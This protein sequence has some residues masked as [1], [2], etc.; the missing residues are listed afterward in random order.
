MNIK[1]LEFYR[2]NSNFT[3]NSIKGGTQQL[4]Y[5]DTQSI[6][7]GR[8]RFVDSIRTNGGLKFYGTPG[9]YSANFKASKYLSALT[10]PNRGKVMFSNY[11][12]S[13]TLT[14][15]TVFP[16]IQEND[17]GRTDGSPFHMIMLYFPGK[18]SLILDTNPNSN[19]YKNWI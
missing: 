14:K 15:K 10:P 13:N 9:E 8:D 1:A 6:P 16:G 5:F 17:N 19:N 7:G 11:R 12:N 18:A 3:E 2:N 4:L